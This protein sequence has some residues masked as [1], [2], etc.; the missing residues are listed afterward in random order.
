MILMWAWERR[1][2]FALFIVVILQLVLFS[3][4]GHKTYLF[5]LFFVAGLAWLIERRRALQL[6]LLSLS[7]ILMLGIFSHYLLRD[8]WLTGLFS[9]RLL[10]LPAVISFQ[11]FEF[12]SSNPLVLLSHGIFRGFVSYP[13]GLEPSRLIGDHYYGDKDIFANT[14]LLGD[15]FMNFG[16]AGLA[17][18]FVSLVIL[19]Y[20]IDI[21]VHQ[22]SLRI[23]LGALAMPLFFLINGAFLTALLTGGVGIALLLIFFL[24][25]KTKVEEPI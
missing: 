7:G 15:A 18:L 21:T 23:A 1:N 4:T 8:V 24:P 9:N 6:T 17:A 3:G 5:S 20:V 25:K 12:F 14:G 22:K 16:H 13:Y 10:I 11:Y 19:F 2:F